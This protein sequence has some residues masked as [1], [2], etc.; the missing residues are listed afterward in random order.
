MQVNPKI[1]L[2]FA[3]G[4]RALL[5][6]DPN[7]IMIGEI[8]DAETAEEAV[9]AAMTGHV[10]LSTLH[11]NSAAGA[12]PRLLDI[13]VEPYLIAST[14]N[15]VMA[16]RLVRV[17]CPECNQPFKP[18]AAYIAMLAKEFDLEKVFALFDKRGML[19]KGAKRFEDLE[20]RKPQG[21][22]KCGATGYKGR[23]GIHELL[24]VTAEISEQIVQKRTAQDIQA[25]AEK[26]GMILMWQDGFIKSLTGQTT[27]DEVLRVSKE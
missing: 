18:D 11:T 16:Q 20:F 3:L 27:L 12:L 6:Q 4:L 17:L 23:I 14:T 25:T 13:G 2:T 8:R 7:I 1:G 21:C 9:H 24:E 5:R 15:A 19:P 26:N 10:V 22:D